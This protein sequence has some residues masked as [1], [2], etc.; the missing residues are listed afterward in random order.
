MSRDENE[1]DKVSENSDGKTDNGEN[2]P[3]QSIDVNGET[4]KKVVYSL[5]YLWGILF[6]LPLMIMV[7][8]AFK[9]PAEAAMFG[10]AVVF[11]YR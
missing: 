10:V 4:A 9:D 2:A 8:G 5:C 7:F 1:E 6:F 11:G 3:P